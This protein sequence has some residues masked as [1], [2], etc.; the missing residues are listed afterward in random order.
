MLIIPFSDVGNLK[1]EILKHFVKLVLILD[2][3]QE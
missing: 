3:D 1:D 2:V